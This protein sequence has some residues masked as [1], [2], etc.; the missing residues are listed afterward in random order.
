MN[1]VHV[2]FKKQRVHV[3]M[4]MHVSHAVLAVRR[5]HVWPGVGHCDAATAPRI[6]RG[7]L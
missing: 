3:R 6:V 1:I 4:H 7:A 2:L 5:I